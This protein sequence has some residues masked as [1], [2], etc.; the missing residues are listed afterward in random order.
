MKHKK[1]ISAILMAALA[2]FT[3]SA[4]TG[5]TEDNG[6]PENNYPGIKYGGNQVFAITSAENVADFDDYLLVNLKNDVMHLRYSSMGKDE[7]YLVLPRYADMVY[8]ISCTDSE[9]C[10][11]KADGIEGKPVIISHFRGS[12]SEI[13]LTYNDTDN[14]RI[15]YTITIDEDG[16]LTMSDDIAQVVLPQTEPFDIKSVTT[17]EE[18]I[19][20]SHFKEFDCYNPLEGQTLTQQQAAY[21]II[22]EIIRDDVSLSIDDAMGTPGLKGVWKGELYYSYDADDK[23]IF[24]VEGNT[25]TTYTYDENGREICRAGYTTSGG[26]VKSKYVS[27]NG[28]DYSI[29]YDTDG[30]IDTINC[31]LD[32]ERSF[33]FFAN[34]Y[35][36][37][38]GYMVR[39]N[40]RQIYSNG[41]YASFV[42]E[43][44]GNGILRTTRWSTIEGDMK[45]I[46][47]S[48]TGGNSGVTF[49]TPGG[50]R[51]SYIFRND[52]GKGERL[53]GIRVT[54]PKGVTTYSYMM[55][56]GNS[57][58]ETTTEINENGNPV[59]T[60]VHEDG[61]KEIACWEENIF[62][63]Y[64]ANGNR[65][66]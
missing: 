11:G 45:N 51:Y 31:L 4:C 39:V 27:Y 49:R 5:K 22:D 61:R 50:T 38:D 35:L 56:Y 34:K 63:M 58:S 14:K 40:K 29:D 13:L 42:N 48:V 26:A 12:V 25:I 16:T 1:I 9:Y 52:E 33:N 62:E 60:T 18:A 59:S 53:S 8:D 2:I 32:S 65:I 15:T 36:Y 41:L 44:D 66:N 47:H 10:Q 24:S 43:Y 23:L 46:S 6:R 55:E 17:M 21:Y 64:D 20:R 37:N 54:D 7:C 19:E 28:S 57:W 3:L 30:K